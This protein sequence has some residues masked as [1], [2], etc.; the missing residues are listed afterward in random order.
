MYCDVFDLWLV[1]SGIFRSPIETFLAIC[2]FFT[3]DVCS[4]IKMDD[5]RYDMLSISAT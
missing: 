1:P 4:E 5:H 3:V 2:V